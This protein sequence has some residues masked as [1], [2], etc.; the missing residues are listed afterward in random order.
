MS[1]VSKIGTVLFWLTALIIALVSY[2]FLALGLEQAFDGMIGH[3]T[4][5]KLV[6]VLHISAAPIAL[7]VGLFQFLPNL[8]T[9]RPAVHRWCGRVYTAAVLTGG[10]SGLLLAIGSIDRPFAAAGF[11]LLA[12]LWLAVTANGVRLAMA[13][14]YNDH[15]RWMVRS[16]AMTF[17]AVTLRFMLPLFFIFGGMEYAEAS[18]YVAWISWVPNLIIAELYLRWGGAIGSAKTI[19]A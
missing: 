19:P 10:V 11:G 4:Q 17:A 9:R 18:S 13:G 2:R 7:A 16:Y 6:F 3:I 5:R 12:I 14:H 1:Y 8:R 15:R